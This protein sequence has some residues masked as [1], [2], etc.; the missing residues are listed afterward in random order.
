[1][2]SFWIQTYTGKKF[3]FTDPQPEDIDKV[4][5]MMSLS[6]LNRYLGHSEVEYTVAEHSIR[7]FDNAPEHCMREAFAHDFAEAYI[8]DFPRPLKLMI[9]EESSVLKDIETNI[10]RVIADKYSLSFPW[11]SDVKYVDLAMCATE[12]RDI[13]RN[14]GHA[15]CVLPP[16]Y[17]G[18]I[19]PKSPDV[20]RNAFSVI[21]DEVIGVN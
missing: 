11:H 12:K 10:E 9:Y 16:P 20:V 5:I 1:M 7:C 17:G 3:S 2:N 13:V 19:V 18:V 14:A 6:R 21:W 8:G 4:D 15:W